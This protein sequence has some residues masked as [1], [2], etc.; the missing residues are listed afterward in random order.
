[1]PICKLTARN[2]STLPKPDE[3]QV[4]YFDED[5][6]GFGLRVSYGGKRTWIVMYR[7]NGVKRRMKLGNPDSLGLADAREEA[8]E[9]LRKAEKGIDPAAERKAARQKKETVMDLAA[10]YLDEYA[11]KNKRS[12]QKDE[13]MLNNDI[14]PAIGR[15]RLGDVTRKDIRELLKPIVDRGAPIRANHTLEVVRGMFNWAIKEKDL[16]SVNPAAM[17][18]KPGAS[19]SRDRYLS[20]EEFKRFWKALDPAKMSPRGAA[21][22]K[23]LALTGQRVMELIRA[24]WADVD[25]AK[26]IWTIPRN[27]AKNRREHVV[28]LGPQAH[29]LFRLLKAEAGE[30]SEWVFPS[31][32][33]DLHVGR[34]FIEKR[35][36]RI[37]KAA[38][39]SDINV[40]DL[41]RTATTYW[42]KLRIEPHIKKRLLNHSEGANV[43]ATYDRFLY[44]DEKR[45]A[46]R[47]WEALL[48]EMISDKGPEG[49][50]VVEL[51]R[52]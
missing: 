4:D 15:K 28:P 27:N 17:I 48:T 51:A 21:A 52:A 39:I 41:R 3:G 6:P 37:R 29:S 33:R 7:Y 43:T 38:G 46:L 14:L 18:S 42:G 20:E 22:F 35:I 23:V 36:V 44:F 9:A 49:S 5:L 13:S 19:V 40:H 1:M 32:A 34:V 12:W 26:G 2:I 24:R 30:R 47:Q 31:P 8:R 10:D 11:K 45:D 16:L 25:L 50:N